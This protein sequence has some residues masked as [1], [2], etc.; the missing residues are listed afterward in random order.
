[1]GGIREEGSADNRWD[2]VCQQTWHILL[3]CVQHF[4]TPF[5]MLMHAVDGFGDHQD[6]RYGKSRQSDDCTYPPLSPKY[7]ISAAVMVV[8]I[9]LILL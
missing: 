6:T 1:M 3:E 2:L 9:T 4:R 5:V 7:L 8:I